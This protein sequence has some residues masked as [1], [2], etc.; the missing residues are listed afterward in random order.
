MAGTRG[1]NELPRGFKIFH[2]PEGNSER[3]GDREIERNAVDYHDGNVM[4]QYSDDGEIAIIP[5]SQIVAYEP[6]SGRCEACQRLAGALT[7]PCEK[8]SDYKG[9]K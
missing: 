1:F 8:C 9:G 7:A 2:R 4:I 6:G 5:I 3:D